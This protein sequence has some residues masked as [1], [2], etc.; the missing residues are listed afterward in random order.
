M[1]N[2]AW[3]YESLVKHANRPAFVWNGEE[4]TYD[5]FVDS[6]AGWRERFAAL[7]ILPG[8]VVALKGDY[9]PEVCALFLAL[10][11]HHVVVVPIS[12]ASKTQEE[13][14]EIA[15]CDVLLELDGMELS[16]TVQFDRADKHE[17]ITRLRLAG[18]PGLILFSS[19][20][21]GKSKASVLDLSKMLER[22]KGRE[23][24]GTRTITFL[25]LDHIG[26]VNTLFHVLLSGGVVIPVR[27][28]SADAICSAV[29]AHRVE[30]LPTTP[31]FINMLIMSGAL[32]AVRSE[33]TANDHVRD[34]AN[35]GRDPQTPC[36]AVS[37][38]HA[39]A[40]IRAFRTR[41]PSNEV[42]KFGLAVGK[43]GRSRLRAEGGR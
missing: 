43:V 19:G 10:V 39:Q 32:P 42:P 18:A 15:E 4:T 3:V 36:R 27:E 21:T 11:L 20:S 34:R 9:N 37:G 1:S 14:I 13:F 5:E 23:Q 12:P 2:V 25:L 16:R 28:R 7:G 31:T 6:I 29:Q 24:A 38:A 40:D 41:H 26:G 17:L 35:A 22:F 33:L 8:Q 30:L